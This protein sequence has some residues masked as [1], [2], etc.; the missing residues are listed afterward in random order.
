M[1]VGEGPE[2][3]YVPSLIDELIDELAQDRDGPPLVRAAMAHLNLVLIHPFRDGNG[4]MARCLQ[5][6]VLVREGSVIPH[7]NLA[8]ST[9]DIDWSDIELRV[10]SA[11]IQA[12]NPA[13]F[14]LPDGQVHR[15]TIMR[16]NN[17]PFRV[18]NDPLA[19]DVNWRI[20]VAGA[21]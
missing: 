3:E 16:A 12:L 10:Y 4:R 21:E 17:G 1:G 19:G 15:L 18:E 8:Q 20:T 5:S 6:L 2:Y 9:G 11:D 13:L 14:A 7:A